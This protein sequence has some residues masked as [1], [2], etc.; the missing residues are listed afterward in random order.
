MASPYN[1]VWLASLAKRIFCLNDNQLKDLSPESPHLVELNARWQVW[2]RENPNLEH[3][4]RSI[5]GL[6]DKVVAPAIASVDDPEAIPIFGAGHINI[7][8]PENIGN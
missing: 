3:N 7:V 2:R 1:G 6:E 4:I 8:K 5:Y